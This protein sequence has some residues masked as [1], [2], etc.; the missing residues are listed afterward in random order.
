[1]RVDGTDTAGGINETR[2]DSTGRL[3]VR[4]DSETDLN[5]AFNDG[6]GFVFHSTYSATGG[7]EIWYLKNDSAKDIHVN[8]LV[9]STSAS[10]VFT[11]FHDTSGNTAGGTTMVGR[12]GR[13]GGADMLDVTA[14]GSASVTGSLSGD[15]IVAHDVGTSTPWPFQLDDIVIPATHAL[16]VTAATTGVVYVDAFVY[17]DA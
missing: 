14:F 8:R 3:K 4:A 16:V 17:R 12:N 6:R 15:T 5:A 1:M 13:L 10:G 9:V 11:V 2:V 7:E